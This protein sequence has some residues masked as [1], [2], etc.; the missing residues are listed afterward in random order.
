MI[1]VRRDFDRCFRLYLC[2]CLYLLFSLFLSCFDFIF[3]FALLFAFGQK[4]SPSFYGSPSSQQNDFGLICFC[5]VLQICSVFFLRIRLSS[6]MILSDGNSV[7]AFREILLSL[8][9]QNCTD[10]PNGSHF[11]KSMINRVY[12]VVSL[13]ISILF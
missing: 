3:I 8:A 9:T 1:Y 11:P 4:R 13:L 7:F 6:N 2:L 5:F 10:A 12:N